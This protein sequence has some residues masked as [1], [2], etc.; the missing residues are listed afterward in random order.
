MNRSSRTQHPPISRQACGWK[1]YFIVFAGLALAGCERCGSKQLD[2]RTHIHRAS[3]AVF[4][5][6]DIGILAKRQNQVV[7]LTTGIV[8]PA[9]LDGLKNQMSR[10]LGFDPTDADKLKEAGL[11]T[12]GRAVGSFAERGRDLLWILPVSD[13]TKFK[14]T[15]KAMVETRRRVDAVKE[16]ETKSIKITTYSTSWG[17]ETLP[18][19]A[20]AVKKGLGFVGMGPEAVK[21]VA[22]AINLKPE[23]SILQHPEYQ[24][25]D[26]S[27]GQSQ[28]AR[29]IVPTATVSAWEEA[30]R[31]SYASVGQAKALLPDESLVQVIKSL[32]WT[33]GWEKQRITVESR[34]RLNQKTIEEIQTVLKPQVASSN[35]MN[36]INDSSSVLSVHATGNPQKLIELVTKPNTPV[37]AEYEALAAM[38]KAQ[39]GIDLNKDVLSL[40]NGHAAASARL[41]DLSSVTNLQAI[42]QNPAA[43]ARYS[44]AVGIKGKEWKK[45]LDAILLNFDSQLESKGLSR[46]SRG[47]K[48]FSIDT[49]SFND[50]MIMESYISDGSWILSNDDKQFQSMLS[51]KAASKADGLSALGGLHARLNVVPLRMALEKVDVGRL[52]GSG[53]GG[54]MV[55]AAI[56]KV[57]QVLA[58]F[59]KLDAKIEGAPD[60]LAFKASLS[61]TEVEATK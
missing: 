41:I 29:L 2:P 43:L 30:M 21:L 37:K 36:L 50:Q 46:A 1:K 3:E 59:E 45:R 49:V 42:M 7:A 40:L 31:T 57:L 61:L 14:G 28:F 8:T 24:A 53:L 32:G 34:F 35:I 25:L 16:E 10:W 56:A 55:R 26:K 15:V 12:E 6:N 48:G 38:V 44:V 58:R 19:A 47:E 33:L 18:V 11:A 4:E 9:Q 22:D 54:P 27:L 51:K 39:L 52:S 17:N 20:V 60:G 5:V 13:E 23:N